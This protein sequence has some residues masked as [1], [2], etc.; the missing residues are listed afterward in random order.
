ME[1]DAVQRQRGVLHGDAHPVLA[2]RYRD[3]TRWQPADRVEIL[4]MDAHAPWCEQV[5]ACVHHD[6]NR[7]DHGT[8]E[9]G[10]NPTTENSK[11]LHSKAYS[12]HGHSERERGRVHGED[13]LW[14]AL[15]KQRVGPRK[16]DAVPHM[17]ES[18]EG[19]HLCPGGCNVHLGTPRQ[20]V[21]QL[22]GE[23]ATS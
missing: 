6:R 21:P 14:H 11:D 19:A 12:Q 15:G 4:V 10:N 23:G 20:H 2:V 18:F 1:L 3:E 13:S 17:M 9:P 8:G 7:A 22:W 16:D 5:G